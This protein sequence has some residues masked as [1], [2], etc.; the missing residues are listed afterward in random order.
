MG[1]LDV[2][3]LLQRRAGAKAARR[4]EGAVLP[5][6][7]GA[8]AAAEVECALVRVD[9]AVAGVQRAH[10]RVLTPDLPKQTEPRQLHALRRGLAGRLVAGHLR[11]L[12]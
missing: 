8:A 2:V 7:V 10:R 1:Q 4:L 6:A 9:V 3:G 11:G 12:P 5:H